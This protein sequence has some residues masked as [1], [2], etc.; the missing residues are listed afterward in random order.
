MRYDF[1]ELIFGGAYT[2][3]GLFSEFYG[4][5]SICSPRSFVHLLR[6]VKTIRKSSEL[7]WEGY[8]LK[9]FLHL[10]VGW[11]FGT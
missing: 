1:E 5:N 3:R 6:Q 9:M 7:H 11:R 4:N 2:W 10:I 8:L